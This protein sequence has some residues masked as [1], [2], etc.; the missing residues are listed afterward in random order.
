MF[1]C[2]RKAVHK[3]MGVRRR[4]AVGVAVTLTLLATGGYLWADATDMVGGYL[5]TSPMPSPASPFPTA[6]GAVEPSDPAAAPQGAQAS[7][8]QA[9]TA[10]V[11][12][13][14]AALLK[15]KDS[16]GD[17]VGVLVTDAVTS[18]VLAEH[19]ADR[20]M[21]PASTQKLLTALAA[22]AALDLSA[23]L[24]TSVVQASAGTIILVGGGDMML[25]PD[26]G[27]AAEINGRA[28]LGDLADTVAA[29]LALTGDTEVT[30]RYDDTLFS[31]DTWSVWSSD[32][33]TGYAAP[34]VPLA[35]DVGRRSSGEYAPRYSDP[36]KEAA[37]VFA[38]RLEDHGVTVTGSVARAVAPAAATAI[39]SVQSAPLRDVIDYFLTHS[40]NSITEVVGRL[41]AVQQGLPA[42][43]EGATTAVLA[44]LKTLG[45]DTTGITLVDCSGL[46]D[47][48]RVSARTLGQV[49]S[50]LTAPENAQYRDAA[51]GLPVGGWSG[52]LADRFEDSRVTG[53]VRAKTGSLVGVSALAG[54]VMT[55][56]ERQLIF[57]VLIDDTD[58]TWGARKAIDAF[59]KAI[60]K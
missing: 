42:S 25:A 34:V 11:G 58:S 47:G 38:A 30:L 39:A 59:V 8:P 33:E 32:P 23:T 51:M 35:V 52:T 28:G 7:A 36:A 31:S 56:G 2:P 41:V 13:A 37:R 21:T 54:T 43:F 29:K 3:V 10:A 44:E 20:A 15:D 22:S 19:D 40:D 27:D 17:S 26:R 53:L 57:V 24:P 48:S 46:A 9:S 60:A 55:T 18:T 12:K 45:I 14:L 5:T 6:P 16:V 4:R 1:D 50:L 49:V